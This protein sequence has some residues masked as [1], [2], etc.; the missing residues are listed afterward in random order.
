MTNESIREY[1]ADLRPRYKAASR[2]EKGVI[3]DEFCKTTG[4]H[5]GSAKRAL[6]RN[7]DQQK[8]KRRGRPPI[9]RGG[10]LVSALLIVWEA[11]GFICSKYLVYAMAPLV[12][13]LEACGELLL[14]SGLRELLLSM[15][16]GTIDRLLKSH[17]Q[18]RLKQPYV[19]D[20]VVSDLRHKIAVHTF[21]ELRGRPVGHVEA[22]LVLHCG[23]TVKGFHLTSLVAVDIATS[24]LECF[25]VWGKGKQRVAGG[26]AK[27]HRKVPFTLLGVH[28]DNGGEFINDTL[29]AYCQREILE[30]SHSRP[31]ERN[32]QPRVEERNGSF[33][34]RLI[35]YGRYT[36]RSAFDQLQRVYDLACTHAN[37]FK[38][39]AKLI[40]TERRGA[41]VIKR[42]DVPQTPYHRLLASGQLSEAQAAAL[43][44]QYRTLNPLRLQRQIGEAIQQLWKL[45][46]V[47][48]ASE[49]AERL[50]QAAKEAANR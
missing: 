41:K 28:T 29:Y 1:L 22:D 46:A 25:A 23:M 36:S 12:E 9:Y 44:E 16:A 37:F 50:R 35:G 42:Y 49:K 34:R 5:R 11:S 6:N 30:F 38:P 4:Y 26:V 18:R 48:P 2:K 14:D 33:V 8:K 24:W 31:Y 45:E 13:R 10:A 19:R 15:S 17:R 32:D 47:D 7:P 27:L 40:R 3:L 43:R 39:T 21:A 20:R